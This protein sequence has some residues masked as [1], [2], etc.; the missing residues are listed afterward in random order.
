MVQLTV[1]YPPKTGNV[2]FYY[3]FVVFRTLYIPCIIYLH[4][5][6]YLLLGI[7]NICS[8]SGYLHM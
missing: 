1:T 7:L 4:Y 2:Y 6:G 5:V 3:R 8:C